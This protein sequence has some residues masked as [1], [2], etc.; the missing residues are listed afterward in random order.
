MDRVQ[1]ATTVVELEHLDR[2]EPKHDAVGLGWVGD[3]AIGAKCDRA[4]G[5]VVVLDRD[6]DRELDHDRLHGRRSG[7]SSGRWPYCCLRRDL[8]PAEKER[9]QAF[10]FVEQ[11][12]D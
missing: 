10:S 11:V 4:P 7:G 9:V 12:L 8:C 3:G 6:R 2:G 1:E 5:R